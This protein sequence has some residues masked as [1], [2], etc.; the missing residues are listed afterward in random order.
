MPKLLSRPMVAKMLG[1]SRDNVRQWTRRADDPLPTVLVGKSGTRRKVIAS[2]IDPWLARQA[3]R[4]HAAGAS[5]P[6][7]RPRH[8]R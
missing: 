5:E 3:E 1:V 2:E 6:R 7:H 4:E 8:P